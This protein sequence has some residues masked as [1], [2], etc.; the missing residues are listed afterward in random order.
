MTWSME[1]RMTNRKKTAA[2]RVTI[3][4]TYTRSCQ[5]LFC[6]YENQD[7]DCRGAWRSRFK[8]ARLIDEAIEQEYVRF[9][10]LSSK[11]WMKKSLIIY[12]KNLSGRCNCSFSC[13]ILDDA[14]R[15]HHKLGEV[16]AEY[17]MQ[18]LHE[19][20]KWG[21]PGDVYYQARSVSWASCSF[22]RCAVI[23]RTSGDRV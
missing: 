20:M 8:V 3:L 7:W 9:S 19:D 5:T 18:S 1:K 23:W 4:A 21:S 17:L 22:R 13:W 11:R 14:R 2:G 6:G 10:S 12:G 15:T 16:T